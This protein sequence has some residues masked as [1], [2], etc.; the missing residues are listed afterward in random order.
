M[1]HGTEVQLFP[2]CGRFVAAAAPLALVALTAAWL[3]LGA[4]PVRAAILWCSL[5]LLAACVVISGVAL[6]RGGGRSRHETYLWGVRT[7]SST[8]GRGEG[9]VPAQ[10]G[11]VRWPS[12][13]FAG[14][15]VAVPALLALW[16]TMAAADARDRGTSS[17][18]AQAGAV[19][20]RRPVV[21]V[22][23]EVAEG[24]SR[25]AAATADLTVLL[26]SLTGGHA[27]PATFE[28][29]TNR[30]QGI[31]SELYVAY[32]PDR[33]E[34]GAIGD[35]Q[36]EDVERQLAGR[37]L[38]FGD[39]WVIG[40]L[41]ALVTLPLLVHWW[42][43]DSP[44][45][46]PRTVGPDWKALRV[47]ITGTGAH[48]DAPPPGSPEAADDKKRRENTRQLPGLV[49]E[50]RGRQIPFHSQMA[51]EAA[52]AALAN[53]RGW[54]LWHPRQC[55]GRDMV[56]EL[57]GDDG[58]QLPGAVP[59]QVAQQIEEAGLMD[60]AHPDPERQVQTLDL[61]AGWLVTSSPP[62]VVAFATALA[63]L[64]SLLLIPDVG[65]WRLWTAAA[66]LLVPLV[67]FAIQGVARVGNSA[68]AK[69]S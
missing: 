13:R 34:L 59:V 12:A 51:T 1:V 53:A 46:P 11:G 3:F 69:A 54:L 52:G 36:R 31:G 57:V 42:R 15:M 47:T 56:A 32:V 8:P 25:S 27:V 37:A 63:C 2:R 4:T 29:A 55:R 60:A 23:N 26:P 28:A 18:L 6:V 17:V 16:V 19:I 65:S 43:N 24:S 20:E 38:Q 64:T 62:V 45:R 49:L 68:E 5:A 22:E 44:R 67:G 7:A 10:L 21:K 9:A 66:G 58:W 61:G 33:P 50:G 14:V 39:S 40:G 35:D 48:T 30:R 41:W